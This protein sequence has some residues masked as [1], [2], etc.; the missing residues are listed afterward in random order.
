MLS[1]HYFASVREQLARAH[2]EIDKPQEVT[3]VRELMQ[4]L[5]DLD[6]EFARLTT[7]DN[8]LLVA[9]NQTVVA[10]DHPLADNDEVAFFPP[11]TGG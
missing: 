4:L 10:L 11:M 1:V 8:A 5:A 3:S 2:D 7:T 9:V 6:P